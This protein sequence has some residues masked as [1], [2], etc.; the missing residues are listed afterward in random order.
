MSV[1]S[2]S[3]LMKLEQAKEEVHSL[4]ITRPMV[5]RFFGIYGGSRESAEKVYKA[6]EDTYQKYLEKN[7]LINPGTKGV[8][9]DIAMSY[10]KNYGITAE[11]ICQDYENR[12]NHI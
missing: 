3:V 4:F 9:N 11:K 6:M 2:R 12:S 10:L 7:D 8:P 5:I 1:T